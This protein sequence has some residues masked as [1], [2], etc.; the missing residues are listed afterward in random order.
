MI[1]NTNITRR[2]F[3]SGLVYL[4]SLEFLQIGS[5]WDTLRA[6]GRSD[7]LGSR[8]ANILVDKQS[9]KTIGVEYLRSVP[10][11]AKA[12]LLIDLLCSFDGDQ[13]AKFARA[14]KNQL[15]ALVR[16]RQRQDFDH[17]RVVNLRGWILSETECRV[18]ALTALI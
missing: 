17:G 10:S 14:D 15:T 4:V 5:S 13:R 1:T 2:T 6:T 7:D 16:L 3:L 11:E 12:D 18:C 9:A 8:L